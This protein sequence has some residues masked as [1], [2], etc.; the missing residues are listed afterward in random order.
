M[1][2]GDDEGGE[3]I[4]AELVVVITGCDTGFGRELGMEF[5]FEG[6][7]PGV[8]TRNRGGGLFAK[9]AKK[10]DSCGFGSSSYTVFATCYSE[11]SMKQITELSEASG[12]S[13]NVLTSKNKT[14]I[15]I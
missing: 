15:I 4:H 13:K 10:F 9:D 2:N 8:P 14:D 11:D 5:F 3:K 6:M 12:S 1:S 7:A